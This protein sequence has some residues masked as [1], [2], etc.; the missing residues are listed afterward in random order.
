LM[1]LTSTSL[2]RVRQMPLLTPPVPNAIE[3]PGHEIAAFGHAEQHL[4]AIASHHVY[5][6]QRDDGLT[7]LQR[8]T[9]VAFFVH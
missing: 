4:A 6:A 2:A 1:T 5:K 8:F 3:L 7:I 9:G